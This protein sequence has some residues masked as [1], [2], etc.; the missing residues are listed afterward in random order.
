MANN[1]NDLM[2]EKSGLYYHWYKLVF[3]FDEFA[4]VS[5]TLRCSDSLIIA[6]ITKGREKER[7]RRATY[8]STLTPFILSSIERETNLIRFAK[9]DNSDAKGKWKKRLI[10]RRCGKLKR[11]YIRIY[12]LYILLVHLIF[13][14]S[15]RCDCELFK[16]MNLF[17]ILVLFY[18]FVCL[19]NLFRENE[20]FC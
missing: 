9:C 18:W 8:L 2:S 17:L 3:C 20:I 16:G 15:A 1:R 14:F 10:K 6:C 5:S 7:E 19:F 12:L 11:E 4:I 13:S